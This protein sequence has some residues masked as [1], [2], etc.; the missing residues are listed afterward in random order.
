VDE[1]RGS[2][3][4]FRDNLRAEK[5]GRPEGVRTTEMAALEDAAR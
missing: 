2:G 3:A 1:Q 4:V 5:T